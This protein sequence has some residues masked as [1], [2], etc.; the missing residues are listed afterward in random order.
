MED[1]TINPEEIVRRLWVYKLINHYGYGRDEISPDAGVQ[2][3]AE[4]HTKSADIVVCF[5]N[6]GKTPKIIVECKNPTR[7]DDIEQLVTEA[8]RT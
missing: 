5:D 2:L 8:V 4:V 1:G 6:T 3:G 7:K